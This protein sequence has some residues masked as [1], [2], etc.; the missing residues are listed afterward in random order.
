MTFAIEWNVTSIYLWQQNLSDANSWNLLNTLNTTLVPSLAGYWL[1]IVSANTSN[2]V[3]STTYSITEFR[4]D[5]NATSAWLSKRITPTNTASFTPVMTT[6]QAQSNGCLSETNPFPSTLSAVCINGTWVILTS[7]TEQNRTIVLTNTS[8][9]ITGDLR[10]TDVIVVIDSTNVTRVPL[11]LTGVCTN[12]HNHMHARTFACTYTC[13]CT[14]TCTC[15]NALHECTYTNA[16]TTHVFK[17]TR[18]R[19]HTHSWTKQRT[20]KDSSTHHCGKLLRIVKQAVQISL[21]IYAS[22][23]KQIPLRC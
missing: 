19:E 11:T 22:K 2:T 8:S 4:F 13:T 23:R 21:E 5:C 14:C 16:N 15:T 17:H 12:V 7:V 3:P 10:L 9:N 18:T 6:S 20:K 1:A